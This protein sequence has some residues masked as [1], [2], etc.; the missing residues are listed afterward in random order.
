MIEIGRCDA[1]ANTSERER[2]GLQE[3]HY[4]EE[5]NGNNWRILQHHERSSEV[6]QVEGAIVHPVFIDGEHAKPSVNNKKH[7]HKEL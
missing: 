3:E 7:T 2:W 4:V 6:S 1:N 5:E